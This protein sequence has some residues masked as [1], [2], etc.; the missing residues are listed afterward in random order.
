MILDGYWKKELL[1]ICRE[2]HFWSKT[3][4][5][6]YD[7]LA[8]HKINRCLLYS[9]IIIR[10]IA[11]DEKD[12]EN[13]VGQQQAYTPPFPVLKISVPVKRF[14]H[15]DKEKLFFNSRFIPEDYDLKNARDDTLSLFQVCNQI[16]HSY[17]WDFAYD[18]GTNNLHSVIVASDREKNDDIFLLAISD[19]IKVIQKVIEQSNI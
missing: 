13:T 19:W 5:V 8:K 2:L 10:K 4:S 17:V 18:Q 15:T 7:S 14:A 12:A 6:F 1:Q 9:A 3:G 11:D 16:I